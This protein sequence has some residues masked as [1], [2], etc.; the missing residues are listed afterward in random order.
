MKDAHDLR[1][2]LSGELENGGPA[3]SLP[4]PRRS[5]SGAVEVVFFVYTESVLRDREL[6][7]PPWQLIT[8]DPESGD[9]VS[10]APCTPVTFGIE[11]DPQGAV[12]GFGL[13]VGSQDFFA[14]EDRLLAIAPRVWEAFARGAAP[15]DE[16]RALVAEH[17]ALFDRI[18]KKPLRPYYEAIG[19]DYFR[20]SA[21]VVRRP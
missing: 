17:D 3:L 12:E 11:A 5:A 4:L 18:A 1:D 13:T 19:A 10:R 20:F 16:T 21:G 15:D 14:S 6:V 8:V 9:V 2:A 7:Y